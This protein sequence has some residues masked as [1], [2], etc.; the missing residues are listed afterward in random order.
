MTV[1]ELYANCL[2]QLKALGVQPQGR[3]H[4]R[5]TGGFN[6]YYNKKH[7]LW[8][9]KAEYQYLAIDVKMADGSWIGW[10]Q[11]SDKKTLDKVFDKYMKPRIAELS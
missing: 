5:E 4:P 6:G 7:I 11:V 10:K 1:E 8:V 2:E 3:S 9:T